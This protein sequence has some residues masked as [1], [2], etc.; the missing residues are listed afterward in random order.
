[1]SSIL[2]VQKNIKSSLWYLK[3][4]RVAL[5]LIITLLLY[6]NLYLEAQAELIEISCYLFCYFFL[7]F[8]YK[9]IVNKTYLVKKALLA[10]LISDIILITQVLSLTGGPT[11]PFSI[12]FLVY[13]VLTAV[14]LD[15][16]ATIL[17]ALITSLSFF[18]LFF[19]HTPIMAFHKAS[20]NS[21]FSVHLHGMLASYFF[22]ASLITYFLT[23]ILKEKSDNIQAIK[24][25][26]LQKIQFAKVTSVTANAAH[27]LGTPLANIALIAEELN[28]K[29]LMEE[30]KK[31]K[32][33]TEELCIKS[34]TVIGE[35]YTEISLEDIILE[36]LKELNINNLNFKFNI[37]NTKVFLPKKAIKM[38]FKALIQ[39]AFEASPTEFTAKISNNSKELKLI[40]KNNFNATNINLS[41]FYS[42]F[43]TSKSDTK[44]L[45]LGVYIANSVATEL[46]GSLEYR[47]VEDYL[48]TEFS[49]PTV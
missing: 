31:C 19:I 3:L 5:F 23:K 47:L 35:T 39:N 13:V 1:M 42:P 7:E 20:M 40:L 45:G 32:T 49:I 44:N 28:S 17:I 24:N 43:F 16:K 46:G 8:L 41:D 34:G 33:I 38:A 22:V 2:P 21:N 12:F 10:L 9:F 29:E 18:S 48:I 25:I 6:L 27:E 11:N 26:E 15:V 36:C 4:R 30:I 14:M 37:T